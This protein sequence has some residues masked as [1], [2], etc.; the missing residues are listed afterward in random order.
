[1]R[2]CV[3]LTTVGVTLAAAAPA[4]KAL[5][6]REFY[7]DVNAGAAIEQQLHVNSESSSNGGEMKFDPGFRGTAAFGCRLSDAFNVEVE[8]GLVWNSVDTIFGDST[9]KDSSL[10]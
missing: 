2:T 8:T 10:Y 1:M 3:C 5:E 4:A 7:V 6:L 9:S